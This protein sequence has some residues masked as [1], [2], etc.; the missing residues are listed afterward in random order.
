[1]WMMSNVSDIEAGVPLTVPSGN[2]HDN[3]DPEVKVVTREREEMEVRAFGLSCMVLVESHC[4]TNATL[5]NASCSS[6]R[7][8]LLLT[9][10]LGFHCSPS[11][12]AIGL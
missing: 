6:S 12:S 10:T 5:L 8:R 11:S 1:M 4:L 9:T 7:P 3:G 2:D